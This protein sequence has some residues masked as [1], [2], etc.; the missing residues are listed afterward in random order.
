MKDGALYDFGYGLAYGTPPS[1]WTALAEVDPATLAGDSRLWFSAGSPA[2]RWSL[3]VEGQGT[4]EQTRIT[5]VPAEALSGRVRV[6]A[7][8]YRVQEGARRFTIDGGTSSVILRNFDPVDLDRETNADVLLLVTAKVWDAPDQAWLGAAGNDSEGLAPV[9]LPPSADF[10]RYGIPLKCFRTKG[11]DM[12]DL[13][14][15]FVLRTS[16]AADF[17]IG[18]VRLGTDA[19]TVLPCR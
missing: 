14:M 17:A 10:V 11:A 18:E 19:E 12:S 8:N 13:T 3:L 16:G 6:T 7:E 9:T 4:G 15:P 5:T 1:P 2:A